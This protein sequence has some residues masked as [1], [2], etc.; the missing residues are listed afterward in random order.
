MRIH[1][2]LCPAF[3]HSPDLPM[4]V[5]HAWWGTFN[6]WP[7]WMARRQWGR[8][9]QWHYYYFVSMV[10]GSGFSNKCTFASASHTL[11][12]IIKTQD[13]RSDFSEDNRHI[14]GLEEQ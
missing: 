6:G 8:Y 7:T 5:A 11:H 9:L 4:A 3:E 2:K 14:H 1:C 13:Q 10:Y 12:M